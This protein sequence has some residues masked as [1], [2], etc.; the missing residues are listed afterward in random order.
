MCFGVHPLLYL[1]G[2][3]AIP[4]GVSEFGWAGAIT[5]KRMP[6]VKGPIT[7]LPIPAHA[8][9]AIEGYAYPGETCTEGPFGEFTGYYGGGQTLQPAVQVKAVYYRNNPILLGAPPSKPP[10]DSSYCSSLIRSANIKNI[11]ESAGIPGVKSVWCFEQGSS[12]CWIVTS[13]K[14]QYDGHATHAATIATACKAGSMMGKYSIVVDDDIDPTDISDVI[15]AISTRSNPEKDIDILRRCRSITLEPTHTR[16]DKENFNVNLGYAIIRAVKPWPMLS[17][18]TFPH[19]A[20]SSKEDRAA[21]YEKWGHL[22]K[23]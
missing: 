8:E 17:K 3:A 23:S 14:Q 21:A 5:G 22:F 6:V 13:I 15:W 19:V 10:H 4:Y 7:G 12:R 2:S 11:L 9:I 20:T 16:E 1:L 18:G